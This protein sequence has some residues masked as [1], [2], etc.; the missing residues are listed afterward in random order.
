[1]LQ[2]N[3]YNTACLHDRQ[4]IYISLCSN[5]NKLK[6]GPSCHCINCKNTKNNQQQSKGEQ[7][8]DQ[9]VLEEMKDQGDISD[10]LETT[11]DE[12]ERLDDLNREVDSM[13]E[14]IF[15]VPF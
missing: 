2:V 1:M 15:G 9:E 13:M 8:T 12:H 11:D 5:H 3:A 7:E 6:C 14:D 4:D 10:D